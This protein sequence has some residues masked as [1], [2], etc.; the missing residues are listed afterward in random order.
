M[1]PEGLLVPRSYPGNERGEKGAAVLCPAHPR[2]SLPWSPRCF[3]S[4]MKSL[5]PT[6]T[7]PQ[8]GCHVEELLVSWHSL[9]LCSLGELTFS[10]W[11]SVSSPENPE[12][13]SSG[14]HSPVELPD[15]H[16]PPDIVPGHT[17]GQT[18]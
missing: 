17:C 5:R 7:R 18:S 8:P 6:F 10:L 11:A 2:P 15:G 16:K 12:V 4:G 9:M 3:P 1:S 13:A 14:L